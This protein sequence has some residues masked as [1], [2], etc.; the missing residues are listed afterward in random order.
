MVNGTTYTW[1]SRDLAFI[2]EEPASPPVTALAARL[3]VSYFPP[4]DKRA[5]AGV[6]NNWSDVSRW[7]TALS[8]GQATL[9]DALAGKARQ[10]TSN[11][12]TEMERVQRSALLPGCELRLDSNRLRQR[13]R[14]P[15]SFSC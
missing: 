6:F 2:E 8:D 3:A 10:L 1:K 14:L 15:P 11:A 12:K 7:L 4:A 9:D 5:G 13:R